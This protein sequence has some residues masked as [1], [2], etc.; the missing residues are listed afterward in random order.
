MIFIKKCIRK[1][2]ILARRILVKLF[3]P[4]VKLGK[5]VNF[6]KNFEINCDKQGYVSIG[7]G[8]FFNNGC[9]I[10][11]HKSVCI[12]DDC[13]FGENVKIY[14]HNHKFSQMNVRIQ[15]QGYNCKEVVIGRNC[16]IGTN[17]VILA[18]TNIG[19]NVVIGAGVV[20]SGEIPSNVVVTQNRELIINP[21]Q[22]KK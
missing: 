19:D 4:N 2:T 14:D 6:R 1:T 22:Y 3:S 21:V 9:T 8:V 17:V 15:D 10:N 16:W 12:G 7:S 13:I 11:S 18:G 20:I 5:K